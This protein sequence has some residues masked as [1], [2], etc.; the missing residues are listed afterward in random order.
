MTAT[1]RVWPI[2]LAMGGIF[3]FF[4]AARS[5]FNFNEREVKSQASALDK[6]EV[7]SFDVRFKDPRLIKVHVPGRGTRIYWYL[8][9]QVINRTA[10]PRRFVPEFELVTLDFPG[11]HSDEVSP[12]VQEAIKRVEDPSGY[13]DIKNSVTISN[14]P[15]PVTKPDAFPRT[16][17]GV[18]IWDATSA[19]PDKKDPKV[20]DLTD[21]T[22]FS[23]FIRGLSNGFV[24]VDPLVPGELPVTRYK[25]LQMNFKRQGTGL[26]ARDLTFVPPAEWIYRAGRQKVVPKDDEKKPAP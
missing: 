12:A 23:I 19:D 9:Y 15:I 16:V 10:E 20:K 6:G 13:Q 14:N 8:W 1:W 26:D 24:V 25:T 21:S 11:V 18:A 5:Q 4:Q 7:W 17:T 2:F 22:R 3:L